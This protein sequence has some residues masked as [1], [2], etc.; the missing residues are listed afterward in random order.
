MPI[1]VKDNI[2]TEGLETT[3]ASKILEGFMPI[4]DATI[5]K[6]LRNAA[7]QSFFLIISFPSM[8]CLF[9]VLVYIIPVSLL[10][11]VSLAHSRLF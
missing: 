7:S 6:K 11:T 8:N 3:C 1:G 5:V 10:I 4:Y 2:V 9:T